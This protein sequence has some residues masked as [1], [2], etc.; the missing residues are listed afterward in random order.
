MTD[1]LRHTVPGSAAPNAGIRRCAGTR[2]RGFRH[3]TDSGPGRGFRT[4]PPC[5]Y[6]RDTPGGLAR[7]TD[8]PGTIPDGQYG[9]YRLRRH[10]RRRQCCGGRISVPPLRRPVPG[11]AGNALARRP[12]RGGLRHGIRAGSAAADI[13]RPGGVAHR[14][15]RFPGFRAAAGR[16]LRHAPL[17]QSGG[18]APAADT[19]FARQGHRENA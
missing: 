7:S 15:S 5:R 2:H 18:C 17:P 11:A 19:C 1:T 12:G 9:K 6:A 14:K 8:S 4:A 10:A 3:A 13:F 16:N